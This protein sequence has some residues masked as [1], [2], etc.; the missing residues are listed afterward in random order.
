MEFKQTDTRRVS[1]FQYTLWMTFLLFPL[2]LRASAAPVTLNATTSV[3]TAHVRIFSV[4]LMMNPVEGK[5]PVAPLSFPG[6]ATSSGS[7]IPR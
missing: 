3:R 6:G 5:P 7:R 1:V 2:V 4:F